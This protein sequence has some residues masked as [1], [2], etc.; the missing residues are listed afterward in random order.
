MVHLL[1]KMLFWFVRFDEAFTA[2]LSDSVFENEYFFSLTD[3]WNNAD[4]AKEA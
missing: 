4:Q 2:V 1:K 3:T